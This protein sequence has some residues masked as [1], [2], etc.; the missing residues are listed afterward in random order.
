MPSLE[1]LAQSGVCRE[2]GTKY[3]P[4][5]LAQVGK[6]SREWWTALQFA[7]VLSRTPRH[8]KFRSVSHRWRWQDEGHAIILE[9]FVDL[10]SLEVRFGERTDTNVS[11]RD[12]ALRPLGKNSLFH[13]R[14]KDPNFE[15]N[16][17]F[18]PSGERGASA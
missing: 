16:P 13:A 17:L 14:P 5:V 6:G 15:Y 8:K 3:G 18:S 12:R 1:G 11:I 4:F 10:G 7:R 9:L 2:R